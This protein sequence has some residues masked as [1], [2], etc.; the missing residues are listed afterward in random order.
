MLPSEKRSYM[1]KKK[2]LIIVPIII[3]I[4]L[5]CATPI[6]FGMKSPQDESVQGWKKTITVTDGKVDA[7]K[8][9][10]DFTVNKTGEYTVCFSFLPEGTEKDDVLNVDINKLG[11]LTTVIIEDEKGEVVYTSTAGSITLDTTMILDAGK[12]TV[13]YYYHSDA[14]DF[15]SF[16]NANLT[17]ER[18]TEKIIS[19]TGF[20]SFEK[21]A[22]T[23]MSYELKVFSTKAD[24]LHSAL[25]LIW[26]LAMGLSVGILIGGIFLYSDT[27]DGKY[28]YD[29][30]QRVE[31]GKG[32][33]LGFIVMAISLGLSIILH[34]SGAFGSGYMVFFTCLSFFAGT[35]ALLFYLI[36]HE[37]YFAINENTTRFIIFIAMF[38]VLNLVIT[39]LCIIGGRL[40]INGVPS[41]NILNLFVAILALEIFITTFI[42]RSVNEKLAKE[43]EEEE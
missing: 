40:V 11:F 31:Q 27:K 6:I 1:K 33:R 26:A 32:F 38:G 12:Y 43:E 7:D 30:R 29:E 17:C 28:R 25:I 22:I 23:D 42:R 13:N 10:A 41:F 2:T 18:E 37:C 19:D 3:F 20:E 36:W 4:L 14:E 21:N 35:A 39:I 16:A 34:T 9:T 5:L 24:N 8:V 15:R